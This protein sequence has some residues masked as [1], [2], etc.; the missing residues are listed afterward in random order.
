M[1]PL[2]SLVFLFIL[3]LVM[4]VAKP[5]LDITKEKDVLLWYGYKERKYIYLFKI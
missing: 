2:Y 4:Y 1:F 3:G 5:S